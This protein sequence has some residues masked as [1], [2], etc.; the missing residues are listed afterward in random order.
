MGWK[1]SCSREGAA[2]DGASPVRADLHDHTGYDGW[3]VVGGWHLPRLL[4]DER[5]AGG[6]AASR[7]DAVT[8]GDARFGHP[9]RRGLDA[10][11]DLAGSPFQ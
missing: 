3:L 1:A 5:A 7:G 2:R 10:L 4:R 6:L 9:L 8:D 11:L